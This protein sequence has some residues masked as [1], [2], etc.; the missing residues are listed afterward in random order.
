MIRPIRISAVVTLAI[1]SGCAHHPRSESAPDRVATTTSSARLVSFATLAADV[2]LEVESGDAIVASVDENVASAVEF[3]AVPS[4]MTLEH[5]EALAMAHHPVIGRAEARVASLGGKRLQAGLQPNPVAQYSSQQIGDEDS[6]GQHQMVI[7]QTIVTAD[8]LRLQRSVVS[9]E[10]DQA[11]ADLAANRLRVQTDVRA[12]F[13]TALV[14]QQRLDLVGQLREIAEKSV[15][16]VDAMVRAK[17]SSRIELLQA[18]TELQQAMLA[19][20]TTEAKLVGARNR[21]SNVVAIGQLPPTRLEGTLDARIDELVFDKLQS[22]MIAASPELA[23]RAAE[24]ERARRSLRLACA[25]I[26]PNVNTQ[27]GVG[28]D[29][30]TDDTYASIQVSMPL[31]ITNRN[32]G[33]IQ[34][35]RAEVA[36]A[37]RAMKLT[38]L[39]LKQ[40]L[41]TAFQSYEVARRRKERIREEV[42]P[43]AEETLSLSIQAFEA[44]EASFLQLLTV[45]RT[46]FESRLT[47]LDATAESARSAN[48]INGYLLSGSLTA[49]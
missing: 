28:V 30:A 33:N 25:S 1:V 22:N 36:E 42:V 21:L 44:G 26:T 4:S 15:L 27:F 16:S 3:E 13:Q 18:Q 24:I 8:K 32:Q 39:D 48:L 7:G 38:E 5:L 10:I 2:D 9:A 34:R 6:T 46:L 12:A 23:S 20:E 31:P 49:D 47:L 11:N 37:D 17:E 45:Q 29:T 14:A 43:R 19:M 40:R 41:V 35:F